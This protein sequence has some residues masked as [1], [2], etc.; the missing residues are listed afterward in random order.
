MIQI[1]ATGK[2][3][4]KKRECQNIIKQSNTAW[5]FES[6]IF[7]I[8]KYIGQ[9]ACMNNNLNHSILLYLWINCN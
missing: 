1:F 8:K 3:I 6:Q 5:F 9:K 4:V 7:A 2:T